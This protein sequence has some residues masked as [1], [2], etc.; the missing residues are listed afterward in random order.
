MPSIPTSKTKKKK[1]EKP[2]VYSQRPTAKTMVKDETQQFLSKMQPLLVVFAH[3]QYPMASNTLNCKYLK[4]FLAPRTTTT[5][6]LTPRSILHKLNQQLHFKSSVLWCPLHH[7][8][9]VLTPVHDRQ[10][11]SIEYAELSGNTQDWPTLVLVL[12]ASVNDGK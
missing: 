1:D 5:A 11:F 10:L 9:V 3:H 2:P 4:Q 12:Y 7:H 6:K 8:I